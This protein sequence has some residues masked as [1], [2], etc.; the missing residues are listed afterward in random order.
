[1]R[2]LIE[3]ELARSRMMIADGVE[4]VPRF[5][6]LAEDGDT[7]LHAQLPVDRNERLEVL[8]LVKAYMAVK[9]VRRFVMA[10]ELIGP[11]T[12]MAIGVNRHGSAAA[13]QVIRRSPAIAFNKVEW[14]GPED[15]GDEI[16]SMLAPR[17][18]YVCDEQRSL[19]NHLV[20]C[21]DGVR[22]ECL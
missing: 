16:P 22:L 17:D 6:M 8:D 10:T 12:L 3:E 14:V 5:R 11:D 19:V 18:A 20:A 7:M 13:Y 2:D 9:L 1:M 15:V 4:L 21:N